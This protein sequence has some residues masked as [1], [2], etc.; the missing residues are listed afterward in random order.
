MENLLCKFKERIISKFE[1]NL[2]EQNL[3]IQGS[4]SKIHLQ[5]NAFKKLE[6][7]SSNNEQYSRYS[8]LRI[9]GIGCKEDDDG[10]AMEKI[11]KC[12]NVM[13]ISFNENEID[14]AHGMGKPFLNK[15]S[16]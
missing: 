16:N 9:D 3:K 14:R 11:E 5:K 10:D 2:R 12:C 4:E 8:C 7:L 1:D 15:E 6:I 13:G